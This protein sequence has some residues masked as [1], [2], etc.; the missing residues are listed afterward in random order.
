LVE[1]VGITPMPT[2]CFP[3]QATFVEEV[4]HAMVKKTMQLHVLITLTKATTL[5]ASFDL[6][7][8]KGGMYT[9]ALVINY[10]NE[11]WMP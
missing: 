2:C 6:W 4:L 11:S 3:S 5:L 1:E 8:S 7:M 9:F 10:S